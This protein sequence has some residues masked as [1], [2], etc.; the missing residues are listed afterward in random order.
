[1]IEIAGYV[2][3]NGG[4]SIIEKK[5]WF[6]NSQKHYITPYGQSLGTVWNY[7]EEPL[8]KHFTSLHM[9]I[10]NINFLFV[11]Y[12][13]IIKLC[14]FHPIRH[15]KETGCTFNTNPNFKPKRW[16]FKGHYWT[17]KLKLTII[18]FTYFSNKLDLQSNNSHISALVVLNSSTVSLRI[19]FINHFQLV[20]LW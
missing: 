5:C 14:I 2:W 20:Y 4:F 18:D 1:M 12:Y 15:P 19:L 6:G 3:Q 11:Y 13:N 8:K 9:P 16:D 17:I 10:T 7:Q